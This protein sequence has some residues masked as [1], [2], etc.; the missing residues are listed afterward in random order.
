MTVALIYVFPNMNLRRYEGSARRFV[1]SYQDAPG[2]MVDH[3]IY[4][5]VNGSQLSSRQEKIFDPLPIKFIQHDNTGR[6]IGAFQKA[7]TIVEAD[8]L[9][10]FGAHIHFFEPGWLDRMV[11]CFLETGP[12]FYGAWA[13]P[14]PKLHIRTTAFWT[15][16][17]I[18]NAYPRWITTYDRYEFEHGTNSITL[19]AMKQSIPCYMVTRRKVF[20][21]PAC[22]HVPKADCL[23]L[24]QHCERG[25]YG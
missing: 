5:I 14:T 21:L 24:D 11:D 1:R 25:G 9:V 6:D 13:F 18:I 12:G 2:G 19:W 7:A 8:L 16:P 17:Q 4:V 10:F 3:H 22:E 15:M 23:F 20:Q